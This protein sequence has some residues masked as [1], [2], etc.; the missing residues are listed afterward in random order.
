MVYGKQ[1]R[2]IAHNVANANRPG[3]KRVPT[4]FSRILQDAARPEK[5]KTTRE[6][7]IGTPRPVEGAAPVQST[8]GEEVDFAREMTDLA[9]NQIRYEFVTRALNRHFQMLNI[10]ITGKP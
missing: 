3:Y 4:D 9:E 8:D 2:A 1:H 7:H 6:K 10:S 5:L